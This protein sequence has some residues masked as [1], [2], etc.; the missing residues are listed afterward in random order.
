M[1]EQILELNLKNSFELNH[2]FDCGQCFRWNKEDDGSYT[3]VF[4]GNVLNVQKNGDIVIFKGICKGNIEDICREY[5]DLDTNYEEIKNILS[6]VD[7]N[8]KESIKYGEGIRILK[9]DLWE[10]IISFIISAN[11]NIPRIKK[12]IERISKEYGEKIIWNG[13]EYYTFPNPQSLSKASVEDLRALGLG[14][15]DKRVYE[16]TRMILNKEIDL[17]KLQEIKDSN[18]LREELN[19]LPGVGDKVADCIMLFSMKRFDV[20][21]VDVWVRRVMNELYIKNE[22][23]SKVDK[24]QIRS[25][26]ESKY[27]NLAG[28]AQQYLFYWK[29]EEN[30][31]A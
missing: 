3:G 12:I 8:L 5:F 31:T 2:I 24:K 29:R 16:T 4:K 13:E 26:A 23:E 10:T 14:F 21:P 22:D 17:E 30:K 25:L 27:G 7:N 15:R 6:K 19:K 20:F 28:I 18:V 1:K 9:Q 11:N